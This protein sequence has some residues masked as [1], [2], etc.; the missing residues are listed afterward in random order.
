MRKLSLV[1]AILMVGVVPFAAVACGGDDDE[2]DKP[3]ATGGTGG[4]GTGGTD[5]GASGGASGSGATGGGGTGG[6]ATGGTA[7]QGGGA[8]GGTAGQGGSSGSATG[9]T[10]GQGGSGGGGPTC[11]ITGAGKAKQTVSGDITANTT[12]TSDKVW[13][14][15]G[16]V[17][18]NAG[19]TLTIEPCTRIEGLNSP[20]GL[21]I[22]KPGGKLM[23]DGTKDEPILFTSANAPGSRAAGDWGGV[24][25]LGNATANYA[26]GGTADFEALP[27]ETFGGSNAAND[28]ESS[29]T[30][31]YV[32]IEFAGK[33]VAPDK[34]VNGLSFAGVGSGTVVDYVMVSN[35]T[36]DC[37]EWFGG[38]ANATHLVCFKN[39]DDMFDVDTGYRGKLQFLYGKSTGS[40][41]SLNAL[42]SGDDKDNNTRTPETAA[43]V[44][45]MTVCLEGAVGAKKRY[46][47]AFRGGSKGEVVNSAF[48]DYVE[49][50]LFLVH[51]PTDTTPGT[52]APTLHHS[53]AF[54]K[55]AGAPVG[56]P[57]AAIDLWNAGTGNSTTDPG[58]NCADVM[59]APNAMIA[60]ATP[61]AGFDT[62]AAYVGAF[63]DKTDTWMSGAWVEFAEN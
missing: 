57:Q 59:P 32:R 19:V 43:T 27:G 31:R 3:K 61:P 17:H 34:E 10:A 25:I 22:V 62:S 37:F 15:S 38:T 63:K 21:L 53:V 13:Q 28:T 50:G 7:G 29:G 24:V 16:T 49:G 36:D 20:L 51:F 60:G 18:V 56:S 41:E 12:W 55:V 2:A 39:D 8:S 5:G 48:L 54:T 4:G 9:G 58:I 35:V 40:T 1:S 44:Y 42:E 45:N 47:A 23:A 33:E 30:L 11:D 26:G 6:G 46:G 14:L 52:T